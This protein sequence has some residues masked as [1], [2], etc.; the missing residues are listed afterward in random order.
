MALAPDQ[1]RHGVHP[2]KQAWDPNWIWI[3]GWRWTVC[4]Q[5]QQEQPQEQQR[6]H[7]RLLLTWHQL[8][9]PVFLEGRRHQL[10]C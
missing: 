8:L 7:R 10:P 6:Q 2:R 5:Q 1:Q 3:W 9:W 4:L